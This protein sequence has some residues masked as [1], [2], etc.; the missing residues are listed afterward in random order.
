MCLWYCCIVYYELSSNRCSSSMYLYA[1]F[2]QRR[3]VWSIFNLWRER[4]ER[5]F[6]KHGWNVTMSHFT[7]LM[8]SGIIRLQDGNER[9]W[10]EASM[11]FTFP[12]AAT[13]MHGNSCSSSSNLAFT[14]GCDYPT[15]KWSWRCLLGD[16]LA[17]LVVVP[18]GN[19]YPVVTGTR[20]TDAYLHDDDSG[21]NVWRHLFSLDKFDITN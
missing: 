13:C 5:N 19:W 6:T 10:K 3:M 15:A 4:R 16:I 20:W 17:W 18:G 21:A 12:A 1:R 11:I 2:L 9:G 7:N 14:A 8:R